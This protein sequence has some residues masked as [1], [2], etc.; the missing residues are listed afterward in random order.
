MNHA[1]N[2]SKTSDLLTR[3]HDEFMGDDYY[4]YGPDES[5]VVQD[6]E[7]ARAREQWAARASASYMTQGQTAA[8]VHRLLSVGAPM[9]LSSGA[10]DTL[11]S[12][13]RHAAWTGTLAQKLSNQGIMRF[14]PASF[15][16]NEAAQ[17]TVAETWFDI[18]LDVLNLYGFNLTLSLPV[19]D[20]CSA[21]ASDETISE[22]AEVMG[23]DLSRHIEFGWGVLQWLIPQLEDNALARFEE[24]VISMMVTYEN[25]CFADVDVLNDLAGKEILVE[26]EES[27][28]GTLSST[29]LAAIFYHTVTEQLFPRLTALGLDA[30]EAW[31]RHYRLRE[32]RAPR[33]SCMMAI[34]CA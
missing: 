2:L 17:Q 7:I 30:Q 27:N 24:A 21:I 31:H 25:L 33:P 1:I 16:I 18:G 34:R 4:L 20:A 22:I 5:T 14:S 32:V 26:G 10:V 9:D 23:D 28:M 13:Q 29:Q 12:L 19:F 3:L 15:S 8:L 6:A 11:H